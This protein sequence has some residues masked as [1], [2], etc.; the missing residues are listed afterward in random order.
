MTDEVVASDEQGPRK[1]R[2]SVWVVLVVVALLFVAL[3]LRKQSVP[4]LSVEQ[5][6][7]LLYAAVVDAC[8]NETQLTVTETVDTVTITAQRGRSF[9]AGQTVCSAMAEFSLDQPLGDREVI[10][11]SRNTPV[12]VTP[13]PAG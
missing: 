11:G 1:R 8:A 6:E 4:V 7:D 3:G 5:R 2:G 9:C 10:D 12:E 13:L